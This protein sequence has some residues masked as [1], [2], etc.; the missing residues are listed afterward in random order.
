MPRWLAFLPVLLFLGLALIL[1]RALFAG[2]PSVVPSVLLG[3]PVPAFALPGLPGR[4]DEAAGLSDADLRGGT[5]SLVNVWA[6]WCAP[7]RLEAPVLAALAREGVTVHGINYK[8]TPEAA[9]EFLARYGDPF[10]RI[11]ADRTGRVAIDW[12]V[13]GV[14]E[15]YVVSGAGEIL[16][17][18]VGEL[19][20]EDV[21]TLIRPA[22]EQAR[23]ERAE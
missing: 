3:R 11:G 8:D 9:A 14:P 19:T 7:C 10:A 1:F 22:L 21:R 23:T 18:H 6:S 5:P 4:A 2:D 20:A 12:G 15:T 17:R 16:L 13:Y